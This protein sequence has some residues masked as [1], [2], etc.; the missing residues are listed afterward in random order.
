[1]QIKYLAQGNNIL[2]PGFEPSASVSRNRHSSQTANMLYISMY[3]DMS[4]AE[5]E[6]TK[7]L[8]DKTR[9]M[10]KQEHLGEWFYKV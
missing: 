6:G 8:V 3:H 9:E 1:M 4:E 5:K 7:H 2:L 10:N